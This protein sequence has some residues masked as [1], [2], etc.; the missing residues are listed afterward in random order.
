MNKVKT[1]FLVCCFLIVLTSCSEDNSKQIE[2][3]ISAASS[4]KE[5]LQEIE[6]VYE[7][8]SSTNI[9]FNFASSG[10]LSK[11]IQQGAPVDVF[12]SANLENF[13]ELVEES[14]I[15]ENEKKKLLKNDLVLIASSSSSVQSIEDLLKA[16]K[17][18]I[19]TPETVPAGEYAQETLMNLDLWDLLQDKLIFAKDVRQVLSYVE[20]GNVTAGIVYQTDAN[21]TDNVKVVERFEDSLHSPIVYPVGVLKTAKHQE[22]AIQFYEFLQKKSA[23]DIFEKH[24]FYLADEE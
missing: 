24:G 4:L 10:T 11:Q 22:E 17:I 1:F 19:G 6:I 5:A 7:E 14:L 8:E 21:S 16:D 12:L 13:E 18:A 3:T 15:L 20:T 9:H 23:I 2:L